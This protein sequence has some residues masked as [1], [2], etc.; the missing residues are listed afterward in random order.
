MLRLRRG[1]ITQLIYSCSASPIFQFHRLLSAPVPRISP[2]PSFSVEDYLVGTYGLTPAQALKASGKISH[3]KSPSNPDAVL[4]FLAASASPP[5]TSPPSLPRIQMLTTNVEQVRTTMAYAEGLG[6]PCGSKMFRHML[7]VVA[8]LSEERIKVKVE[9]LKKTF[10]W[11]DAKVS[12]AL[13]KA[14]LLLRKSEELQKRTS[15]FL[16]SK[17]G[18]EP[19]YLAQCPVM[20]N[21]CLERRLKPRYYAVKFLKEK[22]SLKR[23]LSYYTVVKITEKVFME[24]FI[25]PHKEA[26]PHLAEDY[27]AACRGELPTRF[28][29]V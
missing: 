3:L 28:R 21:Y 20:I 9:H 18:L 14:P 23:D 10:R 1:V 24:K 5:P 25:C 11:S 13:S 19:A 12:I 16:I 2:N 26:A 7:H 15:E 6:V 27:E 22:G 29:F 4:A 17:V 8:F